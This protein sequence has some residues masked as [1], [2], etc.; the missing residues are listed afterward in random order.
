MKIRL[1]RACISK[2][3]ERLFQILAWNEW[4]FSEIFGDFQKVFSDFQRSFF[5]DCNRVL[6]PVPPFLP[7]LHSNP[8]DFQKF[9]EILRV[10]QGFSWDFQGFLG[11]GGGACLKIFENQLKIS[12]N[13]LKMSENLW[14]RFKW[15]NLIALAPITS[16]RLSVKC[17][18]FNVYCLMVMLNVWC[19]MVNV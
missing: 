16:S 17:L 10:F 9:A 1:K 5:L 8:K 2:E 4:G 19:L 6:P 14:K 13:L 7:L 18:Q 3:F 12:E 11:I 15:K